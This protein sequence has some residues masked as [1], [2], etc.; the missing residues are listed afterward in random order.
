MYY[1]GVGIIALIVH[2]IIN[3]EM[4]RKVYKER[5]SKARPSYRL[6]L[7]SLTAFYVSDIS[8]GWIYAQRWLIPSYIC[9]LMV[10]ISMV[11]SVLLWTRSVVVFT[12]DQGGFSKM[13]IGG[14]WT[15]F[16][17]EIVIIVLNFFHPIM[18]YFKEKEYMTL[19]A[20][21]IALIFQMILYF[22]SAVY[23][24]VVAARSEA[25]KRFQYKIVGL[26]S[27]VMAI[28][29]VL[30]APFPLMPM[31]AIGC[32]FATSLI[33]AYIYKQAI[34]EQYRKVEVVNEK[35]YIDALTGVKNKLAYLESLRDMELN[36]GEEALAEYGVV[37]FDLNGLKQINDTQGHDVGDEYLKKAC[38]IICDN[39]KH[40]PVYRIG[41]DE[42][43]AIL[44][45]NDFVNREKIK[46]HFD[47]C[48]EDNIQDGSVIVAS[49]MAVFNP[50]LDESYTDVFVRADKRMYERKQVLKKL[51]EQTAL[52]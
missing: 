9:T 25:E 32:L 4:M 51:L 46:K 40:S 20:R 37:V 22:S 15:I 16:M 12:G 36:M 3:F 45:G 35:A 23:A 2:M 44:Q 27:A 34:N 43:V 38:E 11:T 47:D 19:P 42:F 6:F 31:Y 33:H 48:I 28:F 8:W 50:G 17:F 39:Y 7:F 1:S 30:Q 14:G 5:G 21:H 41:G 26:A 13:L 52:E 49:G 29:I 10:F 18:F 24:L